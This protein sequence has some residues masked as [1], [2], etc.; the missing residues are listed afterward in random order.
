MSDL[1]G[2]TKDVGF[3]AGSPPGMGDQLTRRI[4]ASP[5]TLR[6][7]REYPDIARLIR[8]HP[9]GRAAVAFRLPYFT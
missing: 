6:A 7:V 4:S 2:Y 9:F 8:L 3:A 5:T 1:L